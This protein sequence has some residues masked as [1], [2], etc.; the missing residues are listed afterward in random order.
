MKN[1]FP[2][3]KNF[4]IFA[5]ISILLVATG[6]ISLILLPFGVNFFNLDIDFIGGTSLTYRL[7]QEFTADTQKDIEAL[8]QQAAGVPASS[9]QKTSGEE[10][11]VVIKIRDIDTEKRAAITKAMQEKF[12]LTDEDILNVEN[13]SPV[14][15]QDLQKI[16][17]GSALLA[18]I[19]MMVYITIR[20]ELTSGFAAVLCLI[21]DLL[22]MLSAYVIFQIPLNL[23]FIAA[24]LTILGY[25]INASIIVF[26]RVRENMRF[27]RKEGFEDVVEKSIWQTMGRTINSSIT[28]LLTVG[29]IFLMGVSSLRAFTLPLIIGILSGAYSSVFLAGP[30][31]SML[32]K[33]FRKHKV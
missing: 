6:F 18:A 4:K 2:I 29:M 1:A 8:V 24:A 10:Q 13:V 17:F 16:A 32:R 33:A 22:V 30:F 27:A 21:H 23:N 14:V 9:V 12:S 7:P 5:I 19:L 25:S 15:G 31:W 11:G 28:T 20:F 26:D 3:V